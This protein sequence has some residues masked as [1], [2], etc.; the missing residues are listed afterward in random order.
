MLANNID[1]DPTPHDVASDLGLHRF[2]YDTFT[3]FH[4]RMD[5][6]TDIVF[7]CCQFRFILGCN[8]SSA[9]ICG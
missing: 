9:C 6:N 4:V 5:K 2:T 7:C 8:V 1:P 3:V